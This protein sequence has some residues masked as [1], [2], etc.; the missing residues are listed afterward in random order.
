MFSF[1]PGAESDGNEEEI[2]S[3]RNCIFSKMY[4]THVLWL[5]LMGL[6]HYVFIGTLNPMLNLISSGDNVRGNGGRIDN[7]LGRERWEGESG[8]CYRGKRVG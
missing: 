8:V 7:V 2:S 6:R 4:V 1:S 3:F 5:C